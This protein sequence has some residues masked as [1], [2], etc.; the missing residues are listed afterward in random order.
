MLELDCLIDSHELFC[1]FMTLL[2]WLM[3]C[4]SVDEYSRTYPWKSLLVSVAKFV[5]RFKTELMVLEQK[6]GNVRK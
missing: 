6:C 4:M 3:M 2:F 5:L 1:K